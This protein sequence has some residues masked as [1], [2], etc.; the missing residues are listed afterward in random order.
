M[1][2]GIFTWGSGT[3][4]DHSMKLSGGRR[5]AALVIAAVLAAAGVLV[6][7]LGAPSFEASSFVA[8]PSSAPTGEVA[9]AQGLGPIVLKNA[10]ATGATA[11]STPEIVSFILRGRNLF[12]LESAVEGGHSPD[13]TVAEFAARYGQSTATITAL[14]SYLNKYGIATSVY[15]DGLDV[16][17]SGTAAEFDSALSVQ[18]QQYKV[19]AMAA[20]DGL[21]TI[22]AQQVHG[23]TQNPYLPTSLGSSVLAILGLTN[24]APFSTDLTHTPKGVTASNSVT[25]STDL[26]RQP[27]AR[28]LRQEL[29]PEPAV[30]QRHHRPGPDDRRRHAGGLRP[31][32]GVLLLEH[33]AGHDAQAAE[34]DHGLQHR[35]R[36]R[37]A[38][39]GGRL[40]RERPGRRAVRRAGSRCA[41]RGLPG[42]EHRLRLRGRL[43]RRGQPEPGRL[44][45][46][47]LGR[48]GD[49]AAGV[50]GHRRGGPGLRAGL[51]RG[52][53][54]TGRAGPEHVR[55]GGQRRRLRRV[56]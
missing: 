24:Y 3:L 44:G 47:Q 50:G 34:P 48:I 35:Q 46:L 56:R 17:A 38:Q 20:H 49:P 23:T 53:P 41:R 10:T 45:V 7:A 4:G 13:L 31:E 30:Q 27:H 52:V 21:A 29:R 18:Q 33:R 6:A 11:A 51:R 37:R 42:A 19:P 9:V 16:T 43:L 36:S 25:P 8:S 14:Q 22:A 40:G 55:R 15:P 39:R 28:R 1:C 2:L 26:H 5:I 32:R 12:S 54:R